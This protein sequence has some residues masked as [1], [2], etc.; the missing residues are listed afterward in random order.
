MAFYETVVEKSIPRIP[1]D[2]KGILAP[3]RTGIIGALSPFFVLPNLTVF[4]NSSG[5]VPLFGMR[6]ERVRL[7][8]Y[9]QRL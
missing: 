4:V 7:L 3:L 9:C 1:M 2:F 6:I 5:S 8:I